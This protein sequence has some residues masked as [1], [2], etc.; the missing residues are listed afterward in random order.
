MLWRT[1]LLARRPLQWTVSDGHSP[2][3]FLAAHWERTGE[4]K[5]ADRV[6][7]G[8]RCGLMRGGSE[9]GRARCWRHLRE[10]SLR[11]GSDLGAA[12]QET[13]AKIGPRCR[14]VEV[15]KELDLGGTHRT[16]PA[17]GA[18]LVACG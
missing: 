16:D 5:A 8:Q 7:D 17:S 2:I 1:L 4:G 14:E 18:S 3:G 15:E 6:I 12:L 10:C 9:R 13:A 11:T